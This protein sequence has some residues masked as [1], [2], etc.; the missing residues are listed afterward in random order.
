[1]KISKIFPSNSIGV[2]NPI[3]VVRNNIFWNKS[4][5]HKFT[6]ELTKK[7]MTKK[8]NKYI[9]GK[10]NSHSI[11]K[12]VDNK[13]SDFKDVNSKIDYL[14]ELS[15]KEKNRFF[16]SNEIMKSLL[17]KN[18]KVSKIKRLLKKIKRKVYKILHRKK[19]NKK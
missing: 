5:T 11:V 16:V 13:L 1:M 2:G 10:D 17:N 14:N 12:Y 19:I 7:S 6:T 9:F 3:K 8:T 18:S 4:S 15:E